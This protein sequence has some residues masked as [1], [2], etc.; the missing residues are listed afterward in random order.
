MLGPTGGSIVTGLGKAAI[1]GK[2]P[3]GTLNVF[4]GPEAN[5]P[6]GKKIFEK[7]Q[8][9]LDRGVDEDEVFKRTNVFPDIASNKLLYEISDSKA[10]FKDVNKK[11]SGMSNDEFLNWSTNL[12][13]DDVLD[14]PELFNA[15]PEIAK[16]KVKFKD[17]KTGGD[18]YFDHGSNEFFIGNIDLGINI[19]KKFKDSSKIWMDRPSIIMKDK[20][21][22]AKHLDFSKVKKLEDK[23]GG[24]EA[25][26]I[27]MHEI[28]HAIQMKLSDLPVGSSIRATHGRSF[29][30]TLKT[31]E[32]NLR[33]NPN[34][35]P[36]KPS[37]LWSRETPIKGLD[38]EKALDFPFINFIT[39]DAGGSVVDNS[40]LFKKA[41][42][43]NRFDAGMNPIKDDKTI[44]LGLPQQNPKNFMYV[45]KIKLGSGEEIPLNSP[46]IPPYIKE[47]LEY[48]GVYTSNKVGKAIEKNIAE[49]TTKHLDKIINDGAP[50]SKVLDEW[51]LYRLSAGEAQA[52][53]VQSRKI[54]QDYENILDE[55]NNL[56]DIGRISKITELVEIE[57]LYQI[58]QKNRKELEKY[59]MFDKSLAPSSGKGSKKE[60]DKLQNELNEA[61][62]KLDKLEDVNLY[63]EYIRK[64]LIQT[65]NE[66]DDL[67]KPLKS[68]FRIQSPSKD[69]DVPPQLL[70]RYRSKSEKYS[71]DKKD[72]YNVESEGDSIPY[73]LD[74]YEPMFPPELLE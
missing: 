45:D 20:D 60:M 73:P 38:S 61:L 11:L 1:K 19:P 7:A 53:G 21:G 3:E 44:S 63:P 29:P 37:E 28:Q 33:Q 69:F 43:K 74:E 31:L 41:Y 46:K 17:S 32:D 4:V 24:D 8:K 48:Y 35:R 5:I 26:N 71:S 67:S 27:M 40:S 23:V 22:K 36:Q 64:L 50:I 52:R 58:I 57:K 54:I 68:I 72:Y 25:L 49:G 42:E 12:R 34:Y 18:A 55:Y 59:A 15:F 9:L 13:V 6:G 65:L 66:A 51:D 56:G 2:I 16:Y 30:N 10:K 47:M 70:Q 14:H 39:K 62:Q